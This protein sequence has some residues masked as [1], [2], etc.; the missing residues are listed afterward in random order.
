M[1]GH[2]QFKNIMH[3]K[4]AQDKKRAKEFSKLVRELTIAAKSGLPDPD[5]NPRLRLAITAA[6][7]AN[8]HEFIHALPDGYRFPV[9]D[10]GE[11]LSGGERQRITIARALLKAAPLLFLD[12]ATSALDSESERLVQE[13][14]DRLRK[15]RTSL[16]IAHRLAT[17]L[18]A[19]RIVVLD[20]GRVVAIG[21]HDELIEQGGL[22]ARLA[23]LQFN[24]GDQ[25][26]AE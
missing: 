19:D 25:L 18:N 22:Y 15:G 26:A 17:V 23:E 10:A 11:R 9:G 16:V 2:S 3:R 13:A 5:M 7:A 6:R 12:E 14:L 8:I 1:A 20:E 24:V 21:N 4:G